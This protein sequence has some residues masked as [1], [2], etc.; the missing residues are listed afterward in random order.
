LFLGSKCL[1]QEQGQVRER[2]RDCVAH[3]FF[4]RKPLLHSRLELRAT[5]E[6]GV[7]DERKQDG[8]KQAL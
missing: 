2:E 5:E 3:I 7:G 1:G 4:L 6:D 8:G